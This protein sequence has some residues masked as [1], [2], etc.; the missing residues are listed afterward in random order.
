M[1]ATY[2]ARLRTGNHLDWLGDHPDL[3]MDDVPVLITLLS[4]PLECWPPDYA[5]RCV[6]HLA[7]MAE[8]GGGCRAISDPLSWQRELRRDT[9]L[10]GHEE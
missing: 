2:K 1:I 8:S 10:P 9:V 6:A 5:R 4:E 3:G 7:R